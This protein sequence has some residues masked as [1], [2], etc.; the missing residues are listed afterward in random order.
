MMMSE[1]LA[2]DGRH[3]QELVAGSLVIVELRKLV[4]VNDL[5]VIVELREL[6]AGAFLERLAC[7]L[8]LREL[9]AVEK[10]ERL[11]LDGH[12]FELV[13]GPL[14]DLFLLLVCFTA[15]LLEVQM[16]LRA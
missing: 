1:R 9:V 3:L 16:Q 14:R 10:F 6:V 15:E 13:A 4:A 7:D 5:L 12:H 11:A 2:C 8:E